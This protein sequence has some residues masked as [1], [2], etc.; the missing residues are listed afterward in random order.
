M[1]YC[2]YLEV[3]RVIDTSASSGDI[4]ALILLA[5]EEIDDRVDAGTGNWTN[6]NLKKL[7]MLLTAES[8]ALND[9]SARAADDTSKGYN[10]PAKKYRDQAE[11]LIARL[12]SSPPS[13]HSA[14]I[15]ATPYEHVDEDDR[16]QEDLRK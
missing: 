6:N 5:D 16:Y 2:T 11:D 1:P 15:V 10:N 13:N 12:S 4:A 8:L 7:S 9:T 14:I 3:K